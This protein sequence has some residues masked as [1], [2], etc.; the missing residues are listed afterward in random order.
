MWRSG[1]GQLK[2]EGL[3]RNARSAPY[4]LLSVY[5]SKAGLKSSG[6]GVLS[7]L[8]LVPQVLIPVACV[9]IIS[10]LLGLSI[11]PRELSAEAPWFW[12]PHPGRFS[13]SPPSSY[14]HKSVSFFGL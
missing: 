14:S 9:W 5:P 8:S 13:S 10:A 1:Q 3:A 12:L 2:L 6:G 11:I 4:L 7:R